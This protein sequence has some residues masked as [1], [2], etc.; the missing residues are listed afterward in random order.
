[1]ADSTRMFVAFE[2]KTCIARGPLADV[3]L[4]IQTVQALNPTA[5]L[6][7]FDASSREL[8]DFTHRGTP[9]EMLHKLAGDLAGFEDAARDLFAGQRERF[10]KLL[11]PWPEDVRT[12]L[13]QLATVAFGAPAVEAPRHA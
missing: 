7:V 4:C 11:L 10:A 12:H 2:G 13:M 9:S 8:V 5:P 3:A 6:L 1:M